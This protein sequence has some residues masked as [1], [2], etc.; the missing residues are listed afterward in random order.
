MVQAAAKLVLEPI[1]EASVLPC[2]FGFRPR[3]SAHQG[4]ECIRRE[5]IAGGR[6]VVEADFADY[7]G[8]L[9]PDLL[10]GL[11]ARRV[12]DRRVLRL[13]RMWIRAGVKEDG[14]TVS[15]STGVPQGGVIPPLLSNIYGH[16][17]DALWEKEASREV[18]PVCGRRC[19]T[20]T[21]GGVMGR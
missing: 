14:V 13:I 8:S 6:W 19:A 18:R 21:E 7:F 3:R 15:S 9:D 20:N 2:S 1:F 10:L 4:L 11:V 5:I 17:L 16:A 12:S